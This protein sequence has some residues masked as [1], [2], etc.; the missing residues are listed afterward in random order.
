LLYYLVNRVKV[1]WVY[2]MKDHMIKSK[3]LTNYKLPYAVLISRMLEFFEVNLE[4]EI[5]EILK[6]NSLINQSMLNRSGL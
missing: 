3:R 5:S 6:Q 1:N 4:D 2:T